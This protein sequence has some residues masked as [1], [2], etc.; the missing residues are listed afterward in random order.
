LLRGDMQRV[1][2]VVQQGLASREH[3]GFVQKLQSQ[4]EA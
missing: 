4:S 2:A 3:A 1:L